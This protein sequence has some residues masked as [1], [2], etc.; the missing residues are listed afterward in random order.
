MKKIIFFLICCVIAVNSFGQDNSGYF[1]KRNYVDITS[2]THVPVMYNLSQAKELFYLEPKT[3]SVDIKTAKWI[4]TS[5]NIGV[6]R[7]IRNDIIIGAEFGLHLFSLPGFSVRDDEMEPEQNILFANQ[8]FRH[9][10][11]KAQQF[12]F[13]TKVEIGAGRDRSILPM[14]YS[15]VIGAGMTFSK[16]RELDYYIDL[17]DYQS[18]LPESMNISSSDF[19]D[20]SVRYKMLKLMYGMKMRIP[21]GKSL[22][23]SYGVRYMIDIPLTRMEYEITANYYTYRHL[24]RYSFRNVISLDIGLTLPW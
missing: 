21:M 20:Y 5:F 23:F 12:Y 1:G 9:E 3:G 16:I 17:G 4:N 14:G 13:M 19:I 7:A 15:H 24:K 8:I 2:I 18:P 6:G 10:T 11:L 22:M